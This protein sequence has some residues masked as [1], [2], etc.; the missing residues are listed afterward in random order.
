MCLANSIKSKDGAEAEILSQKQRQEEGDGELQ[1]RR[2][3]YS[4]T[5]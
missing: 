3:A 1:K 4:R 5:C 2:Q